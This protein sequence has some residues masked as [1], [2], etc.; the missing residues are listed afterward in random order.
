[1]RVS[2]EQIEKLESWFSERFK[3][4]LDGKMFNLQIES[5]KDANAIKQEYLCDGK[6]GE[7]DDYEWL[8][9]WDYKTNFIKED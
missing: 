4:L 3:V 6:I 8:S 9:L 2:A 1:M 5:H 7:D